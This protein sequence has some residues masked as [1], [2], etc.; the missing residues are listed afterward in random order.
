MAPFLTLCNHLSNGPQKSFP[1]VG[2]NSPSSKFKPLHPQVTQKSTLGI[3]EGPNII[4]F[5]LSFL[6][7]CP[8]PKLRL[9]IKHLPSSPVVKWNLLGT[10]S[11][12]E[13]SGG[14]EP[15]HTFTFLLSAQPNPLLWTGREIMAQ[16]VGISFLKFPSKLGTRPRS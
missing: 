9:P 13:R 5:C 6:I 16:T 4:P 1:C 2:T 7:T 14:E 12:C 11:F 8:S 10:C 3:K 15:V